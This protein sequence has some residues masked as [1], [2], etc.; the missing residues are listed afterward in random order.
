M[1]PILHS[2]IHRD[3]IVILSH[4]AI[5]YRT[6]E[7]C[8]VISSSVQVH[9]DLGSVIDVQVHVDLSPVI[10]IGR[11]ALSDVAVSGGTTAV[12]PGPIPCQTAAVYGRVIST[13]VCGAFEIGYPSYSI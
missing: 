3:R 2:D 1:S 10:I 4:I 5:L 7:S 6:V 12:S 11:A 9:V 8:R 13:P